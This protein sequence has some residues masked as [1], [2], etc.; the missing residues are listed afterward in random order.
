MR[1]YQYTFTLSHSYFVR[2]S[3]YQ[4]A[5]QPHL[6][7]MHM[8]AV[9]SEVASPPSSFDPTTE[10]VRCQS[11][12]RACCSSNSVTMSALTD[13]TDINIRYQQVGAVL[14]SVFVCSVRL[15]TYRTD[16]HMHATQPY[17]RRNYAWCLPNILKHNHLRGSDCARII[18]RIIESL[19]YL[20]KDNS[21][22][23]CS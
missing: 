5:Y 19:L 3:R 11:I 9:L 22:K 18:L 6:I 15:M 20:A 23:H 2:S 16:T 10:I 1:Q 4:V 7:L 8:K 13:W 14:D 12:T 17:I 21:A